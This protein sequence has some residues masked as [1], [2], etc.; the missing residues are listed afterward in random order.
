MQKKLSSKSNIESKAVRE[1]ILSIQEGR[2]YRTRGN[3]IAKI[4][5]INEKSQICFVIH[6]PGNE[7]EQGPVM[8]ELLTGNVLEIS[9]YSFLTPPAY[10]GH[11]SDLVEEVNPN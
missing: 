8:H 11:P 3:W 5:H 1:H 10:Y 2:Y 4:I 6:N 9:L 7:F